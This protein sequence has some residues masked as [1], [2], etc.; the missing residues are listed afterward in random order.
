MNKVWQ[1][2]PFLFMTSQNRFVLFE[3]K[4]ARFINMHLRLCGCK[5]IS[6]LSMISVTFLLND[7][8]MKCG[9]H[10]T[11]TENACAS[12]ADGGVASL[13]QWQRGVAVDDALVLRVGHY[14]FGTDLQILR[15]LEL[16]TCAVQYICHI[17]IKCCIFLNLYF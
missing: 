17:V 14:H 16:Y 13:K 4:C 8:G 9:K 3:L 7:G 11:G 1:S 5:I 2:L 15:Q 12:D 10:R 6:T